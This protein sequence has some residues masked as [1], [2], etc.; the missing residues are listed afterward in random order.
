VINDLLGL[1]EYMPLLD[2]P[3][4]ISR[5]RTIARATHVNGQTVQKVRNSSVYLSASLFEWL[6]SVQKIIVRKLFESISSAPKTPFKR[7]I[8]QYFEFIFLDSN[9]RRW[10]FRFCFNIPPVQV[11]HHFVVSSGQ[12]I[13]PTESPSADMFLHGRGSVG[14]AAGLCRSR[15]FTLYSITSL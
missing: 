2:F 11:F 1:S 3:L 12:E 6:T 9:P 10:L 15:I 14:P 8:I 4:D 5:N 7:M 13:L